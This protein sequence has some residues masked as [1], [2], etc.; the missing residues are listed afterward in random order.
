M[1]LFFL[2]R[3]F[4]NAGSSIIDWTAFS[5]VCV[6]WKY[7]LLDVIALVPSITH[8]GIL[9][10]KFQKQIQTRNKKEIEEE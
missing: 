3:G 7:R 1:N 8:G 9:V 6:F 2:R 10:V 4:K 5:F